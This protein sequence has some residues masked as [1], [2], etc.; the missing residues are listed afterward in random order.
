MEHPI[1]FCG[2][3]CGKCPMYIATKNDDPQ[4]RADA[5]RML[6][7]TYGLK[8]KPE[9]INCDGCQTRGGRLLAYCNDCKVRACGIANGVTDCTR[10]ADQPCPHLAEFHAFSPKA[11]AAYEALLLKKANH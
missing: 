10:C 7:E 8:F 3:D 1:A 11:K 5:S 4:A 2:L 9:E 6:E